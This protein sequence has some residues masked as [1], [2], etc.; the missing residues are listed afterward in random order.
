MPFGVPSITTML[1]TLIK[2]GVL[3]LIEDIGFSHEC[4]TQSNTSNTSS[5][6]FILIKS[7]ES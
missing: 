2:K 3:T 1:A 6:D 5:P 4:I 7:S